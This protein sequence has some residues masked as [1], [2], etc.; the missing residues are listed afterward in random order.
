MR[1]L[2]RGWLL[3]SLFV[4]TAAPAAEIVA[5]ESDKLVFT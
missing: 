3:A 1:T 2:W 5:A 4:T